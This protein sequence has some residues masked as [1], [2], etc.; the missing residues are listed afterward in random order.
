MWLAAALFASCRVCFTRCRGVTRGF[1]AL[2]TSS[3]PAY[4]RGR[5]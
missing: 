1:C 3:L 4:S 5:C 2:V